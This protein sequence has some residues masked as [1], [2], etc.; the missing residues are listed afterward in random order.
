MS[1]E[2][3][4]STSSWKSVA[5]IAALIAGLLLLFAAYIYVAK[6]AIMSWMEAGQ[7]VP[8]PYRTAAYVGGLVASLAAAFGFPPLRRRYADQIRP[9]WLSAYASIAAYLLTLVTAIGG[10]VFALAN[11]VPGGGTWTVVTVFVALGVAAVA[12]LRAAKG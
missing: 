10:F 6:W 3:T 2:T 12:L 11:C 8:R 7:S 1:R 9:E 4:T 5:V